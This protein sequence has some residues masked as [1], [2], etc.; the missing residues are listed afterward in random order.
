MS[1][2]AL[3]VNSSPGD[4]ISS[5]NYALANM[6]NG[7][8]TGNLANVVTANVT[9]GAISTS[10]STYAYLYQYM[11]VKY[12]N[13]STGGGFTSNSAYTQYY[14]IHNNINNTIDNNPTDYVWTQVSGGFGNTKG[15]YYQTLGGR[16][17]QFQVS[18]T[19]QPGYYFRSVLDDTPINLD[20][21]TTVQA[22]YSATVY[23][24]GNTT[25]AIPTG[26]TY[27]FGNL[28]LTPPTGWSANVPAIDSNL[29]LYGSQNT[30]L[31]SQAFV[32]GPSKTWTT[33]SIFQANGAPGATGANGISGTSTYYYPAYTQGLTQPLTPIYG[34]W[35]FTTQTGIPPVDPNYNYA[36]YTYIQP[37]T[38]TFQQTYPT[39]GYQSVIIDTK[40]LA[41]PNVSLPLLG[42]LNYYTVYSNSYITGNVQSSVAY[43]LEST[44]QNNTSIGN[45]YVDTFTVTGNTAY[46][47]LLLVGAGGD[48]DNN[49]SNV[50]Y[51]GG[52]AGSITVAS[53]IAL[54]VGTYRIHHG[55]GVSTTLYNNSGSVIAQANFGTPGYQNSAVGI[56]AGNGISEYFLANS[57]T[58][59]G[60]A[61]YPSVIS[62]NLNVIRATPINGGSGMITPWT[63]VN[64]V[65]AIPTGYVW[66]NGASYSGA[67]VRYFGG[68]GGSPTYDNTPTTPSATQSVGG[69]G[70]GGK[71]ILAHG[72]GTPATVYSTVAPLGTGGA[73]GG[74][75][76]GSSIN[77][78]HALPNLFGSPTALN[79]LNAFGSPG[80]IVIKQYNPIASNVSINTWQLTPPV[81]STNLVYS[82]FSVASISGN[83]GIAGNLTWS[84]PVQLTGLSGNTGQQG[85]RG[86]IPMAYVA[87][88]SN[89]TGFSDYQYTTAFSANRTNTIP[90]NTAI[91]TGYSPITG[92]VAQFVYTP[93]NTIVVKSFNA[94]NV[95]NWSNVDGQV[96]SGNVFV[97]GSIN[98]TALNANDVFALNIAS[99]SAAGLVGDFTSPGFWL[100]ASSGNARIAGNTNI[101]GSLTIGSNAVVGNNLTIGSNA[102]VGNNLTVGSNSAIGGNLTVGNNAVIGGNLQV[103]GLIT[104]G[105]LN[106]NTVATT[107]M[108]PNS[109]T[110]T[111]GYQGPGQEINTPTA[112][113][114]GYDGS[115]YY[116]Q[117]THFA[118]VFL[119]VPTTTPTITNI[120]SGYIDLYGVATSTVNWLPQMYCG[121]LRFVNA[122]LGNLT[123]VAGT[124]IT[125]PAYN[126]FSPGTNYTTQTRFPLRNTEVSIIDIF[127]PS[128]T[129]ANVGYIFYWG[130]FIGVTSNTRPTI[131]YDGQNG[132][133]LTITNY[134]R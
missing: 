132:W 102:V 97:T 94:N 86:F 71:G 10:G 39:A 103:A 75:S 122:D 116:Y 96:I 53:N 111:A 77:N 70:G 64:W 133:D 32:N 51:S 12:A 131:S 65:G 52:G 29:Y 36:P 49:T 123:E 63:E 72:S 82:T 130:S 127:T 79:S 58:I 134:R 28:F 128:T 40:T 129:I 117:T 14:G 126:V 110:Y 105:N 6:N 73:G 120:I 43:Y 107:T 38:I 1:N 89:P 7:G 9:T 88:S 109:A 24:R 16:Q 113:Y 124:Y 115:Y 41:Q 48:G 33:P 21:V 95:P 91:G 44:G 81:T 101:G 106:A 25:P 57:T 119:S 84:T 54:P 99:T 17:I 98:S 114:S 85:T 46:V 31:S 74:G 56:R 15:L 78:Q 8:T 68:G 100:Q 80:V 19:G 37:S 42:N 5:L 2:F 121:L 45:A 104:A 69:I 93:T 125:T 87:V 26:G 47:D 60:N 18:S 50:C 66:A 20:N 118:N 34:S 76:A 30:F 108:V 11:D 22:I 83:T 112:L 35:N 59:T 23:Q 90:P 67:N 27:N 55:A 13:T 3:D 62:G 92:D 61:A 4:I